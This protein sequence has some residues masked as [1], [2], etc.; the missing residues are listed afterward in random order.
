MIDLAATRAAL[1][2]VLTAAELQV[3]IYPRGVDGALELP[4][5]GIGQPEF[6]FDTQPCTDTITLPVA[7]AVAWDASNVEAMQQELEDLVLRVVAVLRAA[8]DAGPLAQ[9][10]HTCVVTSAEPGEW[11]VQA[12]SYP[13]YLINLTIYG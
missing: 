13:A 6:E 1:V 8:V 9:V 4:A 11:S 7:V 5:V 12:A 10:G 2:D 3:A